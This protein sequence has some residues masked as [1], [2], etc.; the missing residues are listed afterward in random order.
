ME[1][2]ILQYAFD[3]KNDSHWYAAATLLCICGYLTDKVCN[4]LIP[5][6]RS[7]RNN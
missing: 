7:T 5:T 1:S 3:T 6:N 2:V 4:D